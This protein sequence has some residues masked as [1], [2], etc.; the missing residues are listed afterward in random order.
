M[1]WDPASMPRCYRALSLFSFACFGVSLQVRNSFSNSR[2]I[3][4]KTIADLAKIRKSQVTFAA[5][6]S[7]K[8]SS[9]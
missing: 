4:L 7:I 5:F 3:A 2:Y 6:N 9:V 1:N 8:I